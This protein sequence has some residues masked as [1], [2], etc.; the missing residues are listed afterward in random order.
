MRSGRVLGSPR[1][2]GFLPMLDGVPLRA[3]F[4]FP[5]TIGDAS[6]TSSF[7]PIVRYLSFI[8][9]PGC[10]I[11]QSQGR[12]GD[13]WLQRSPRQGECTKSPD[14]SG[15]RPTRIP[16]GAKPLLLPSFWPLGRD[17]FRNPVPSLRVSATPHSAHRLLHERGDP[18]LLWRVHHL[19]C[20]DRRPHG[21]LI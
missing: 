9:G 11:T 14:L 2:L 21:P 13:Q 4:P 8:L 10:G 18:G 20:V 16:G 17:R 7:R 3:A 1:L 5:N 15:L 12:H 6:C 19:Q